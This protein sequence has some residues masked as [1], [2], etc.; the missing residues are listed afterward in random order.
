[1]YYN[2]I[3]VNNIHLILIHLNYVYFSIYNYIR[4]Y[5]KYIMHNLN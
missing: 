5:I 1:M 4:L 2:I 3:Y